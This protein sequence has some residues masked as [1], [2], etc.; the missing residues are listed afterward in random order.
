VYTGK[1][2]LIWMSDLASWAREVA[3]LLRPAGHLFIH[4]AHPTVPLWTWDAGHPGSELTVATSP[5]VT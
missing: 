1:G 3:R 5:A 4:D 2:A